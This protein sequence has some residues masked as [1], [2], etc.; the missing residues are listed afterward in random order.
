MVALL[1]L[2]L[3]CKQLIFSFINDK[4]PS[5]LCLKQ[6]YIT[7]DVNV[8]CSASFPVNPLFL[9]H[10]KGGL[11]QRPQLIYLHFQPLIFLFFQWTK[12]SFLVGV[13]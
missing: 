10:R 12:Y 8:V 4:M 3:Y 5:F 7:F 6:Q 9:S 11:R 2:Y 1:N 13:Y